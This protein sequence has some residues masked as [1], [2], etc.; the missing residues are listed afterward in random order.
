MSFRIR[1]DCS[2]LPGE[3]PSLIF[4]AVFHKEAGRVLRVTR[5]MIPSHFDI[6]TNLEAVA[7][8]DLD[9]EAVSFIIYAQLEFG[10]TFL[11][12]PAT[13][14]DPPYTVTP[15]KCFLNSWLPPA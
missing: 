10:F 3:Y 6:L 13:L 14:S 7:I 9:K 2:C 8:V 1:F 5:G 11:V 4:A 15:G 12:R